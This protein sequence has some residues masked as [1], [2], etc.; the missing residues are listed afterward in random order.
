M[1][2]GPRHI[3]SQTYLFF[4]TLFAAVLF[5]IHTPFLKLPY[6]W[7]ELGLATS[8]QPPGVTALL[9][10]ARSIAGHAIPVTRVAMLLAASAGLLAVFLLAIRL[11]ENLRG[12]PAFVVVMLMVVSPIFYAQSMLALADLPAMLFTC[13]A[14]LLFLQD[15]PVASAAACTLLALVKET[16]LVVPIVLGGWLVIEKRSRDAVY[17]LAPF[18][19]FGIWILAVKATGGRI[20]GNYPFTRFNALYLL[21]PVRFPLALLQRLY[22]LF[23]AD[24]RW[25]GAL[26]IAAAWRANGIFRTRDWRIS[27]S[28]VGAHVLL[29]SLYGGAVLE[30]SLLPVL[31]I[32]YMAMVAA[33]STISRTW[34]LAGQL[35]LALGLMACNFWY[36][37]YPAPLENDTSFTDFV[38]LQK[39]A[40]E[41]L[42]FNYTGRRIVTAWPLGSALSSPGFGYVQHG[43]EV[44]QIPDFSAPTLRAVDWPQ[45]DALVLYSRRREPTWNLLNLG[46]ARSVAERW[47]DYRPDVTALPPGMA[48]GLEHVGHWTLRGQW[49]DV[50]ATSHSREV[51]RYVVVRD[52]VRK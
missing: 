37:P 9:A 3:P 33:F 8:A 25:I 23:L 2:A 18:C 19:A 14:L 46:I 27:T 41:F 38:S 40:A 35:G 20:L 52:T 1:T 34:R 28:L 44:R 7:D 22:S 39:I 17:F 30:R 32:V 45:V 36:P 10:A 24:F 13:L 21:H 26:A 5:L 11:S 43:L 4:Y 31:P 29:F 12:A 48:T 51:K 50:Y 15:R 49:V 42:E 16:G 47:F 6:F